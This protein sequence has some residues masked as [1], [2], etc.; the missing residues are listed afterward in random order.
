MSLPDYVY[1]ESG[2]DSFRR[3]DW[4]PYSYD[5]CYG[6]TLYAVVWDVRGKTVTVRLGTLWFMLAWFMRLGFRDVVIVPRSG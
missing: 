1:V 4:I 5:M 3:W 2:V 6:E